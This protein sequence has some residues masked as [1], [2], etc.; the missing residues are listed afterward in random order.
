M[1]YS[2][3]YLRQIASLAPVDVML[4]D[5]AIRIQLS[6]TDYQHAIDHYHAINEWL[7]REGSPVAGLVRNFIRRAASPSARPSRVTRATTSS[8]ST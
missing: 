8:T 1:N 4:A 3:R 2:D 7:E 6:P 5:V